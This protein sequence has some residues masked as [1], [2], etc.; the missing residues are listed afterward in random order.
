[1]EF[2]IAKKNSFQ[3]FGLYH[4]E[5]YDFAVFSVSVFNLIQMRKMMAINMCAIMFITVAIATEPS[6]RL[7]LHL[8]IRDGG[9]LFVKCRVLFNYKQ[10]FGLLVHLPQ[11]HRTPPANF[12]FINFGRC[13]NS[14]SFNFPKRFHKICISKFKFK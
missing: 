14:I 7:L 9:F 1:M 2:P 4:K 5:P 13:S 10:T 6:F 11:P 3:N 8:S 12:T